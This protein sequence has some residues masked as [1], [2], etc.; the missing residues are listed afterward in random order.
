MGQLQ[1]F[2]VESFLEGGFFPL[3]QQRAHFCVRE[4]TQQCDR[5]QAYYHTDADDLILKF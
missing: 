4:N 2:L 1:G 5:D 3:D